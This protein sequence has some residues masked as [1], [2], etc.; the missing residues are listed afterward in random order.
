VRFMVLG[1]LQVIDGE[2]GEP[3]AVLAP[4][5]RALL[6]VLLWRANQPV[7]VD[8]LA[9]LVWDGAPP[10]GRRPLGPRPRRWGCGTARR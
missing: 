9:E 6:A 3:G 10:S 4:R 8:E 1:P 5:L 2:P 7:P